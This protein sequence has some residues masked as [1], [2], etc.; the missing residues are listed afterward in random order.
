MLP[1][2]MFRARQLPA[3]SQSLRATSVHS[4]SAF[5]PARPGRYPFPLF[6]FSYALFC[7]AEFTIACLLNKLHTL[8][9]K[10]PGWGDAAFPPF[11]HNPSCVHAAKRATLLLS[12]SYFM[13]LGHAGGGGIEVGARAAACALEDFLSGDRRRSRRILNLRQRQLST[14]RHHVAP[15]RIPRE[16]RHAPV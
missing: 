10:Q 16:H 4:A 12:W 9:T 6:S 1:F 2:P 5:T 3:A 8:C 7:I 13:T 11:P 14:R 15:A